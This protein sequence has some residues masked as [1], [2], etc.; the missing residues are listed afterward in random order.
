MLWTWRSPWCKIDKTL[1]CTNS[2]TNTVQAQIDI[3]HK[4]KSRRR[5]AV[6]AELENPWVRS[7][8]YTLNPK[9]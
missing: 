3:S 4:N 5:E 6:N 7:K 2:P 1:T 9:P 8:P